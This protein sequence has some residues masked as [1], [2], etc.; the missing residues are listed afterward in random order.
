MAHEVNVLKTDTEKAT[1]VVHTTDIEKS[2]RPMTWRI[3]EY[4]FIVSRI[5]I[6]VFK[7]LVALRSVCS[8]PVA[9]TIL[10]YPETHGTSGCKPKVRGG[11]VVGGSKVVNID[12][13]LAQY[14]EKPKQFGVETDFE[15][16]SQC[17]ANAMEYSRLTV[18]KSKVSTCFS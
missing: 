1:S 15:L 13:S 6:R 7:F 16:A 4:C 12:N 14:V 3:S 11:T 10:W 5:V 17:S 18:S 2:K 8:L 9:R